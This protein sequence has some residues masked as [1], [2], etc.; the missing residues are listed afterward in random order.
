MTRPETTGIEH[1]LPSAWQLPDSVLTQCH[2]TLRASLEV[3]G[4]ECVCWDLE[5]VR[6]MSF[7][8]TASYMKVRDEVTTRDDGSLHVDV[9]EASEAQLP[10]G[11]YLLLITPFD[12]EPLARARL[13]E[14]LGLLYAYHGRNIAYERV[15]EQAVKL[16]EPGVVVFGESTENPLHLRVPALGSGTHEDLKVAIAAIPSL[17]P[18][19]RARLELS[20]RWFEGAVRDSGP[21]ALLRYWVAIE[22]LAMPKTTNVKSVNQRLAVGYQVTLEQVSAEFEVG[23]LQGLRSDLVHGS[24]IVV[25]RG[26]LLSYVAALYCDLLFIELALPCPRRAR[27][28]MAEHGSIV[29]QELRAQ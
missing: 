2:R 3:A 4:P 9:H 15:Y 6:A 26:E 18:E 19:L 8:G 10:Q 24:R 13:R 29:M 1:L 21:D 22:A 14:M 28:Y 20:L 11:R 17:E 5:H 27:E 12:N 25:V 16:K 7:W 23:R